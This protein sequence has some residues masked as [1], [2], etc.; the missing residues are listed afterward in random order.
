MLLPSTPGADFV[1]PMWT[2]NEFLLAERRAACDPHADPSPVRRDAGEL[3]VQIVVHDGGAA[4][5]VGERGRTRRRGGDVGAR[6]GLPHRSGRGRPSARRGRDG[7]PRHR[8]A[9]GVDAARDGSSRC[10]SRSAGE[11]RSFRSR[12]AERPLIT[13]HLRESGAPPGDAL[14][15]AVE[16]STIE[17]GWRIWAAGEAAAMYRIRHHLFDE[18]GLPRVRATVRG[19][20]KHGRAGDAD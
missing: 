10:T 12:C 2:G 19:Y 1:V 14:V 6:A 7:D 11:R 18:L 15:A 5:A 13:W 8:P 20:W 9:P 4:S 16:S 3:E 17:D